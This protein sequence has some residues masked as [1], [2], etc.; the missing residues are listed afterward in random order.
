MEFGVATFITDEGIGPADLGRALE[1]RGFDALFVAE[2]TH[3]P[4]SR[5]TPYPGGGDLR[6]VEGIGEGAGDVLAGVDDHGEAAEVAESRE[7]AG[8]D[9]ADAADPDQRDVRWCGHGFGVLI[10]VATEARRERLSPAMAS[11]L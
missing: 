10:K 2:H 5:E 4:T 3:I 8:V 7:R 1:E 11:R 9:L 6:H